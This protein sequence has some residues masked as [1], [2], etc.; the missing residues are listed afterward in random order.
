MAGGQTSNVPYMAAYGN[1]TKALEKIKTASTPDR[2][3][4]DFLDTKIGLKGGSARPVIPFLK[5]TGFL[6]SDGSP[7][8]L[9][10]TFRNSSK[11]GHAAANALKKGYKDLYLIH[12]YVHD[13]SDQ[14]LRDTIVQASGW[15]ATSGNVKSA[16]G[17]FKALRAFADFEGSNEDDA[18]TS[19]PTSEVENRDGQPTPYEKPL[20]ASS[21]QH[22][23]GIR[24]GY[25]I[26]LNLPSTTDV[27]VF[28]AIFK[29]LKE[30]LL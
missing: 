10:V 25:T 11:S 19:T 2:F 20:I 23:G 26:N 29:S 21:S 6:N 13:L 16:V 1:I 24:L 8:E 9:Y 15:D 18:D 17:S 4:Q 3:T 5:R 7:T 30:H 28:N 27:A 14:E 22:D 12:E